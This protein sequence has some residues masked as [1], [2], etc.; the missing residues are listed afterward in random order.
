MKFARTALAAAAVLASVSAHATL[1]A[2]TI[3]TSGS[4]LALAGNNT[5]HVGTLGG[6]VANIT[7]GSFLTS[8]SPTADINAF[9][10]SPFGGMFLAA[11][12][13]STSP[14][15]VTFTSALS[16]VSFLWGSPDTYNTLSVTTNLGSYSFVPGGVGGLSFTST[17]GNQSYAQYVG[18]T[19]SAGETIRSL[20]FASPNQDAFEAANFSITAPVPEPETYA[21]MLGG[22]GMLGLLARRR[23][24]N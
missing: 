10:T 1:T 16:F 22:L 7:G 17:N 8:D 18:F 11:G 19:A 20:T 5:T 13:T 24:S 9:G 14:A 21:L 2:S 15:V 23:K 4:F 12:P 6:T 3:P